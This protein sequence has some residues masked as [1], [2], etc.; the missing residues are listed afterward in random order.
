M[1]STSR[2]DY[3]RLPDPLDALTFILDPVRQLF[4]RRDDGLIPTLKRLSI[5]ATRFEDN[6]VNAIHV[7]WQRPFPTDFSFLEDIN[8]HNPEIL[9]A[10]FTQMDSDSFGG[11]STMDVL[12]PDPDRPLLE[13][14]GVRWDKLCNDVK[15]CVI[16]ECNLANP[17][18]EVVMVSCCRLRMSSNKLILSAFDVSTELQLCNR[19]SSGSSRWRCSSR[20]AISILAPH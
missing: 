15:A 7:D 16:A 17:I 4:E 9:A 13:R 1:I 5:L 12:E 11:L 10:S 18:T 8:C 20:Q 6:V 14:I 2:Y 3:E 19:Y